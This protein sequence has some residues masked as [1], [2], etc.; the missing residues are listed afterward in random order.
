MET[1]IIKQTVQNQ[2]PQSDA[3][4]RIMYT[5]ILDEI[6]S[7]QP[8]KSF[9]LGVNIGNNEDDIQSNIT[10]IKFED[11]INQ[12]EFDEIQNIIDYESD[13]YPNINLIGNDD[14]LIIEFDY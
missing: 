12:A 1:T 8:I 3:Q 4:T 11:D 5:K 13:E 7:I 14:I 9:T 10:L 6:N 2:L